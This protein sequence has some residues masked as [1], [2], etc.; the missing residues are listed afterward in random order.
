[1]FA[2]IG[3]VCLIIIVGRILFNLIDGNGSLPPKIKEHKDYR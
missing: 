1:M 2:S 3:T